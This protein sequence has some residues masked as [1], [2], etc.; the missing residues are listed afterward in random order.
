MKVPSK[1]RHAA[2]ARAS[3]PARPRGDG[4]RIALAKL[5]IASPMT[6]AACAAPTICAARI[7]SRRSPSNRARSSSCSRSSRWMRSSKSLVASSS[8]RL[9]LARNSHMVA[10]LYARSECSQIV[11]NPVLSRALAR[12]RWRTAV[13]LD[14]CWTCRAAKSR[15]DWMGTEGKKWEIGSEKSERAVPEMLTSPIAARNLAGW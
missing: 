4:A 3:P 8:A 2:R 12:K 10:G 13:V 7:R 6:G 14:S 11:T 9:S 15:A 5:S 1:Y